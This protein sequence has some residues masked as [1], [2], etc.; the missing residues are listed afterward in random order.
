MSKEKE[1]RE[2]GEEINA[3]GTLRRREGRFWGVLG[4]WVWLTRSWQCHSLTERIPEEEPLLW[5]LDDGSEVTP[6]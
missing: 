3:Q 4:V 6:Q 2:D 1:R 5:S